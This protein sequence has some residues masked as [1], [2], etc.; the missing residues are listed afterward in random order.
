MERKD[1]PFTEESVNDRARAVAE[2]L[3]SLDRQFAA[4]LVEALHD[5]Q[6]LDSHGRSRMIALRRELGR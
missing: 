2:A 1:E 5:L 6:P 4:D 3:R